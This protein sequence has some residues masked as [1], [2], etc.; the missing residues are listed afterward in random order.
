MPRWIIERVVGGR[1]LAGTRLG[2]V[3]DP[4]TSSAPVTI[5]HADW[6]HTLASWRG[7]VLVL[8]F[9]RTCRV[10]LLVLPSV[11]T[12][13][14]DGSEASHA[15]LQMD[16]GHNDQ[17]DLMLFLPLRHSLQSSSSPVESKSRVKYPVN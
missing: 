1:Y 8:G 7:R 5:P 17:R 9:S 16:A 11:F 15:H 13:L 2:T 6:R 3:G 14:G 10:S 4:C 12:A